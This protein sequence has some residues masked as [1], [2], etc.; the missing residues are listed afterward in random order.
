MTTQFRAYCYGEPLDLPKAD[1][2]DGEEVQL[3]AVKERTCKH[4]REECGGGPA[5]WAT[6]IHW[7]EGVAPEGHRFWAAASEPHL[8]GS[9]LNHQIEELE[10]A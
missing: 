5:P 4:I 9:W 3:A 2:G 1:L 10:R 6:D 7:H 8:A